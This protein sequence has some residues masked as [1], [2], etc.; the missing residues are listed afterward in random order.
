M[1]LL[2]ELPRLL[3]ADLP[4][5]TLDAPWRRH[6]ETHRF[7]GVCLFRRN[8]ES[9][10]Q[11]RRL[12]ADLRAV[13]GEDAL[14]AVDQEGGAVLRLLE[15]PLVPAP[16]AIGATGDEAL[17]FELGAAAARGLLACGVNWNFAPVLDVN[18]NPLNPV[19]GERSFGEDPAEV[20]RLGVA[21][22][23]GSESAGVL[24]AVKHFPGHG[25]TSVDSHLDLPVVRKD[26]AALDTCEW[27]PFREA[28]RANVGSFMT[29][30]ILYP[31]LDAEHPATLSPRILTGLL[32]GEWGY[33]GL[34]VTD[35][36]DMQAIAARH[37]NGEGAALALIA[38]ADLVLACTHGDMDA[39]VRQVEAVRRAA[40]DGRLTAERVASALRRVRTAADRFPGTPK[41]YEPEQRARDAALTRDAARRAVTAVGDPRRPNRDDRILLIVPSEPDVGGPYGDSVRGEHVV[42]TLRDA[43]PNLQAVVYDP[44]RADA[45]FEDVRQAPRDFTLFA[46]TSRWALGDDELT[47]A[48]LAGESAVHL[49]LWNPY[50]VAT[51]GR[52]AFVTYGFRD[53]ALAALRDVLLGAEAPGRLPVTLPASVI[54]APNELPLP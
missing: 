27:R 52:A 20:A 45:A 12:V 17:S 36:T 10:E 32:R 51:L 3:I 18:D 7:G 21:W 29:A 2:T 15:G 5:P 16:M 49:A 44:R 34:V 26:R 9:P 11:L 30:H 48:K 24:S 39:Q 43:F 19:I 41:V 22:A 6:F 40:E 42:R 50:H 54:G 31:E 37:P 38:G 28:V 13:L 4:G 35:A 46:T 33:D 47:L 23:L 1:T 25:D 14:I 53:D 8:I